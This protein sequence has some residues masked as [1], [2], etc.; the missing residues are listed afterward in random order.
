MT[1]SG[2]R[3]ADDVLLQRSKGEGQMQTF[4]TLR[5]PFTDQ[6]NTMWSVMNAHLYDHVQ[7]S[8]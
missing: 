5:I 7:I 2:R 6:T 4:K 1:L 8:A 3:D